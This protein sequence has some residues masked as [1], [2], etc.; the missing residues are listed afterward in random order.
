MAV[1]EITWNDPRALARAL[2]LVESGTPEGQALLRDAFPHTGQAFTLGVTGPPGSGKSSLINRLLEE[3]RQRWGPLAVLAIDPSSSF[4]GGALLGD[5]VRMQQH[6]GQPDVFIRS[7][8]TRGQLGGLAAA[9]ADAL[10]LLDAAGFRT[11]FLET[12]GVGQNEIDVVGA[13]D[14]TLLVLAP[15]FGD[16]VQT[17]K[18]GILEIADVYVVNKADRPEAEQ[19]ARQLQEMLTL[20]E[21]TR[22]RPVILCSAL[23]GRG[24]AELME[25]LAQLRGRK[26]PTRQA[27]LWRRRLRQ[28]YCEQM[29]A[30]LPEEALERAAHEVALRRANPY[31]IVESW[32]RS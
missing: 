30:R 32:V 24:V 8:A 1:L 29:L 25:V 14:A 22:Q 10:L 13:A 31:E 18:A 27:E 3:T 5:R 2:T 17:L 7:M 16:A 15:G 26:S 4:T 11:I 28:L 21:K 23:E 6:A 20:A 9:T 19:T 12:A